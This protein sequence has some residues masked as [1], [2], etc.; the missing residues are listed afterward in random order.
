[1]LV[2]LI[3]SAAAK[4]IARQPHLL[5]YAQDIV[6]SKALRKQSTTVIEHDMGHPVGYTAVV[7]T[8]DDD[9]VFYARLI[10]DTAYTRFVKK[11]E[12]QATQHIT[13]LL[14]Y[15]ED[16]TYELDDIWIGHFYPPRPGTA[17]ATDASES[18]W[19]NHAFVFDNQSLQPR[20]ISKVAPN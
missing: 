19:A 4:H 16:G 6:R 15:V 13:L 8:T 2:N 5:G 9:T 14:H 7:A 18:F 10:K 17:E 20:T 12:P 3:D 1:V 11:N